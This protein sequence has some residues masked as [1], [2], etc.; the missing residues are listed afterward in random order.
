MHAVRFSQLLSVAFSCSTWDADLCVNNLRKWRSMDP[1]PDVKFL[2]LF[3]G[4]E[5]CLPDSVTGY[6]N[7]TVST[8]SSVCA[9]RLP[10]PGRLTSVPNF[11]SSLSLLNVNAVIRSTFIR[12]LCYKLPSVVIFTIITDFRSK[13]LSSLLNG[14]TFAAFAWYSVK[15]RVV[16]D[17]RF[18]RRKV[19]KNSNVHEKW[20]MQTLF[21]SLLN[22]SAKCHQNRSWLSHRPTV[23][24]LVH[25]RD[26]M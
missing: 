7:S 12:K 19:N 3:D 14:V 5:V 18:K 10:L 15:I 11:T 17:V 26:T 8:F 25:F 2:W 6:S 20:N 1:S 22:I 16:F 24:K 23:S 4:S 21:W 9:L 13:Q